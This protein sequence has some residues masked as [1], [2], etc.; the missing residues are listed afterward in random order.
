M[1]PM[2]IRTVKVGLLTADEVTD[3][4]TEPTELD[5]SVAA[6]ETEDATSSRSS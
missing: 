6:D 2:A 5:A 1:K 3:S 4:T